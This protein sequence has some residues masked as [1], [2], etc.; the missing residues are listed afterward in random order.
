MKGAILKNRI[1]GAGYTYDDIAIKLGTSKQ[2]IANHITREDVSDAFISRVK[3]Y[4]PDIFSDTENVNLPITHNNK[5][6]GELIPFYDIDFVAGDSPVFFEDNIK[7]DY[8]VDIPDFKGC[9]AFKIHGDSMYPKIKSG[10]MLLA[11]KDY[12]WREYLE[13]GQIYGIVMN[14]GKKYLKY[15]RKSESKDCFKL[16]SENFERYDDFDIPK[17]K[18][19]SIWLIE[20]WVNRNV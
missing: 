8:Y 2:N 14:D 16:V 7:P 4:F 19:K 10:M 3:A 15:I 12:N 6:I 1:R 13:Y 11:K 20:G 17:D 18:I 9:I 5:G